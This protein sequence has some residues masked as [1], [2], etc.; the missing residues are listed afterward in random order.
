MNRVA[1][2]PDREQRIDLEIIVDAYVPEEQAMGW[3]YY[4]DKKLHFPF[5]AL[6]NGSE[7]EVVEMS[8]EDDCEQQ[9]FV[10][11]LYKEGEAEDIFSVP[12]SDIEVD[13]VDDETA[14]AIAD[15]HYWLDRGYDFRS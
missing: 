9:M 12:L 2:D 1:E 8:S 15:W 13:E 6:W 14:E 11:V 7:V 5:P 10:E 3:Y 4:L